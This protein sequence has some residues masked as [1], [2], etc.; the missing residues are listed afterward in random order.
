[1]L[2]FDIEGTP[3][4]RQEIQ[5]ERVRLKSLRKQKLR[6]G[7]ISDSLHALLL[8]TLYFTGILSGTGFIVA[9]L[10]GTVIAVVLATGTRSRLAASDRFSLL[11]IMLGAGGAVTGI[12]IGYFGDGMRSSLVAGLATSSIVATGCILGRK[13]M[14]VLTSIESLEQIS[15][16]HPAHHEL[17][18][19][20]HQH[21]QLDSYRQQA[22]DILRPFLAYGE[23][24]AMQQWLADRR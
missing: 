1:M 24:R 4:T 19:L 11:L 20:C 17:I 16:D 6:L 8:F 23:L 9:V 12:L 21:V 18:N 5:E 22:R 3:P 2:V 7:L 10:F 14:A 15:E 13:I